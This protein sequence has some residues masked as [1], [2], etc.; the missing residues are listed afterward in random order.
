MGK[1]EYPFYINYDIIV[2]VQ[3]I[4]EDGICSKNFIEDLNTLAEDAKLRPHRDM[5]WELSRLISLYYAPELVMKD[6]TF[7]KFHS[8]LLSLW[9]QELEKQGQSIENYKGP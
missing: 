7:A 5:H 1:L 6:K 2:E 4:A 3:K 8:Y 9:R